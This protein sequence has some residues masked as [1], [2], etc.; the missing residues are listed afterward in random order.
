MEPISFQVPRKSDVFQD[1]IY[2]DCFSGEYTLTADAW[3]SGGNGSPKTCSLQGGFVQKPQ[4]SFAPEKQAEQKPMT[5]REMKE[6]IEKLAK[7]VSYL[8]A[9]LVK[10]DAK[11]KDLGG[12]D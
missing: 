11:I 1:D 12:K 9:E 10:R 7:R 8:E 5:E 6:E 2:P 3:L 4:A